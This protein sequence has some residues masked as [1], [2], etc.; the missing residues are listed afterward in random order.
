VSARRPE[1]LVFE[2]L[3]GGTR[4]ALDLVAALT[5]DHGFYLAGGTAI[6]L[7]LGHRRSVDLDWFRAEPFDPTALLNELRSLGATVEQV[8][9]AEGTLHVRVD[10][11]VVSF[12]QFSYPLLEEPSMIEEGGFLLAGLDDLACM[13]L[14]ALLQRAERK[15]YFDLYAFLQRGYT[16]REL[17]TS[18]ERKFGFEAT[19]SLARAAVYFDDAEG[20]PDP[21]ALWPDLT[22]GR[23]KDGLREAV[24]ELAG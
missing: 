9:A 2:A 4:A 19:S 3:A 24:R 16:L 12:L 8:V 1:R 11:T 15:D 7:Y 14:A 17:A 5:R 23:V 18:F 10:E 22:W 13:K 6:G 20:T 21:V